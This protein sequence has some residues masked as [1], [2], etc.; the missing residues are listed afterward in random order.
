MSDKGMSDNGNGRVK[1]AGYLAFAQQWLDG[2]A[3]A[4]HD[5]AISD[6]REAR[7]SEADFILEYRLAGRDNGGIGRALDHSETGVRFVTNQPLV[8]GSYVTVRVLL[9]S[10]GIPVLTCLANVVRCLTLPNG[11]G[12]AV[13]CA[14]D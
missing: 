12:Y 11:N 5:V 2:Q 10:G 6:K 9:R 1:L 4:R 7:R 13:G 14:Y 3:R 8:R